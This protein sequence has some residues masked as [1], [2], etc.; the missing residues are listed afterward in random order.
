MTQ[1][2]NLFWAQWPERGRNGQN[3]SHLC[4]PS[5]PLRGKWLA[6]FSRP[7]QSQGMLYK[8]FCA[9]FIHSVSHGL[10]KYIHG[11][12][13][14]RHALGDSK[15]WRASRS[16]GNFAKKVDFAYWWSFS[17][18]GSASAACAAGLFLSIYFFGFIRKCFSP[19]RFLLFFFQSF[20]HDF[21]DNIWELNYLWAG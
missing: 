12:A 19:T 21:K 2:Q 14:P 9:S 8:H 3:L 15:S 4:H 13:T 11:T 18:E 6:M 10:W 5:L 20:S 17:D 16:Y 7:R 1:W